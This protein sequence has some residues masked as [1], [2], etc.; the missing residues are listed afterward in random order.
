[1]LDRRYPG[2]HRKVKLTELD[3][4]DGTCCVTAQL[5]LTGTERW[6]LPKTVLR[7][8]CWE[9]NLRAEQVQEPWENEIRARRKVK[10]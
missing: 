9:D 3:L 5:G 4:A 10:A 2:W 8:T 6:A 1:M 7:A